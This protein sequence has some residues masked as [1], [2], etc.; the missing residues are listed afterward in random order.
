MGNNKEVKYINPEGMPP[1]FGYTHV[2]EVKNARSIYISG[3]LALDNEGQIVGKGDLATQTKQVFEN[4]NKALEAA[5]ACFKD[6]VKLTFFLTD[7]SNMKVVREIR[8][9]YV[10]TANPPA[11]SAVEVRKL[12]SEDF[13]IEIEAIAVGD[14]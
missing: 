1:T 10:N 2:V 12:I 13:L 7:I 14:L 4:I 8:D 3:Q 11:S 5:G 6:V 9:Q